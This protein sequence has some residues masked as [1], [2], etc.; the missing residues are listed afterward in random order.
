MAC[1]VD[2]EGMRPDRAGR[3][4]GGQ[5]AAPPGAIHAIESDPKNK[6]GAGVIPRR[7]VFQMLV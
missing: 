1:E 3:L 7:V 4:Q 5:A 6:R 2:G